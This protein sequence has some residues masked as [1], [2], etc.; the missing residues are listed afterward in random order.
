[1]NVFVCPECGVEITDVQK[2]CPSCGYPASMLQEAK[3]IAI[4]EEKER[5]RIEEEE[6]K[7]I[8][9]EEKAEE[10]EAKK[11]P[12]KI[13]CEIV[14]TARFLS[15]NV[16][17]TIDYGQH[18]GFFSSVYSRKNR[19]V[20]EEGKAISFNSM[21]DALNYM[22]KLGWDFEQAYCISI[23]EGKMVENVYHYLLSKAVGKEGDT[24]SFKTQA[25]TR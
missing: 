13:F 20:D 21:I 12:R 7:K 8:E 3:E 18:N 17:V 25:M 15:N 11:H 10:R 9:E 23:G 1:M 16:T 4:K 5:E 14:G 6:R 2:D 22:A 19:I 24:N